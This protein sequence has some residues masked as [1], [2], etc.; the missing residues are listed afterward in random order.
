MTKEELTAT[1]ASLLPGAWVDVWEEPG[2]FVIGFHGQPI[3]AGGLSRLLALLPAESI[4]T[5]DEMNELEIW[6]VSGE[7]P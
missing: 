7:V 1:V 2:G 3:T 5:S 4:V 6:V